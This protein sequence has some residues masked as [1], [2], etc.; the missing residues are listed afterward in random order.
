MRRIGVS[1]RLDPK[2]LGAVADP[3]IADPGVADPC[4]ADPGVA[5][6]A[7]ADPCIADPGV[8]GDSPCGVAALDCAGML[9][10]R[11][12]APAPA[13]RGAVA[14]TVR[15]GSGSTDSR[16]AADDSVAAVAGVIDPVD[17]R[18]GPVARRRRIR[19]ASPTWYDVILAHSPPTAPGPIS[20]VPTHGLASDAGPGASPGYSRKPAVAAAPALDR[21]SAAPSGVTLEMRCGATDVRELRIAAFAVEGDFGV[22]AGTAALAGTV[23]S[24]EV[25]AAA[26]RVDGEAA[27]A[28]AEADAPAENGVLAEAGTAVAT[29]APVADGVLD[30]TGVP[31]D[32]TPDAVTAGAVTAARR[33]SRPGAAGASASSRAVAG[34]MAS[35]PPCARPDM[36]RS[37]T[38]PRP[39][40]RRDMGVDSAIRAA[41]P[42]RSSAV[43]APPA[44]AA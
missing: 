16:G 30:D 8:A 34:C 5:G 36:E 28:A 7:V 22:P 25:I 21:R 43:A 6:A 29:G 4:V 17:E 42:A 3:C 11:A 10:E 13:A 37:R 26:A 18:A 14:L 41:A 44:S 23:A 38:G 12:P 20:A 31:A 2:V 27:A 19:N 40:V 32:D 1:E 35:G 24:A 9:A 15:S 39:K 33:T